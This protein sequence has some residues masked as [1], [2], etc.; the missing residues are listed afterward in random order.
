MA[1]VLSPICWLAIAEGIL[2]AQINDGTADRSRYLCHHI[3][4]LKRFPQLPG[5]LIA[6]V[7][8]TLITELFD[9]SQRAGVERTGQ[10][11][12]GIAIVR[13]ALDQRRR[14]AGGRDRGLAVALSFADTSV[15]SRTS[16]AKTCSYVN[17]NQEMIGLG[18]ANVA[19]GFF[20]GFPISSSSSRTPVAGAAGARTQ[21]AGVVGALAV[22]LPLVVGAQ[23]AAI[24]A[25]QRTGRCGMTSF[26]HQ[27][28]RNPRPAPE[29]IASRTKFWLSIG[30]FVGV[31]ILGVIPGIGLAILISVI[32]S[33]L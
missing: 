26:S 8:A 19:A 6:A 10:P 32:E 30:C 13:V 25:H 12:P 3:V 14:T 5:V 31:L 1:M 18:I 4:V 7:L 15:L 21:L 17:P 28:V 23:S 2:A 33:S 22:T 24:P 29:S 27:P 20:Q 11:A 9:L 16:V